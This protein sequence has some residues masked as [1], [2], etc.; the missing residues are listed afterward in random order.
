[1]EDHADA[2]AVFGEPAALE[3]AAAAAEGEL[4]RSDADRARGRLLQQMDAAQDGRLAAAARADQHDDLAA[5]DPERPPAHRL[6][7]AECDRIVDTLGRALATL[8]LN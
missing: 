6:T 1:L 4:L 5:I 8:D 2:R 3:R 7:R